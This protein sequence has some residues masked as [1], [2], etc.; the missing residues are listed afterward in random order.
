[1][2]AAERAFPGQFSTYPADRETRE[3]GEAL[4][5]VGGQRAPRCGMSKSVGPSALR[6]VEKPLICPGGG[7]N[8][9]RPS[10]SSRG[11]LPMPAAAMLHCATW[12]RGRG[13]STV[14]QAVR[15]MGRE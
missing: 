5:V 14:E 10:G 11:P 2:K 3:A 4:A 6:G 12:D 8:Q 1:V 7:G 9:G 15:D 13:G